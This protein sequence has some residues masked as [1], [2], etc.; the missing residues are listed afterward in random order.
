MTVKIPLDRSRA[1]RLAG[2]LVGLAV[3]LGACRHTGE[4]VAESF[5]DDYR[6]RHPIVIEEANRSDRKSV[7]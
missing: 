3:V 5:P 2:A 7:V 6:K 1:F 4:A